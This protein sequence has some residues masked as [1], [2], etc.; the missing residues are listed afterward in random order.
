MSANLGNTV[1]SSSDVG[2]GSK[3]ESWMSTAFSKSNSVHSDAT[4]DSTSAFSKS[5][6]LRIWSDTK[7]MRKPDWLNYLCTPLDLTNI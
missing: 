4:E 3:Y 6:W 1:M 7:C 5:K 2:S